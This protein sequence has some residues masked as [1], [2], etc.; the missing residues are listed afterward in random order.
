M[1]NEKKDSFRLEYRLLDEMKDYP[2][3]YHYE[4]ISA[5]ELA[6]RLCCGRFVKEGRAYE[7]TSAAQEIMQY[8]IYLQPSEILLQEDWPDSRRCE[9]CFELRRLTGRKGE[10]LLLNS[11]T[12][13]D[14]KELQLILLCD[15]QF[16]L[17]EEH[18][19][20]AIE[21]NEDRSCY[22]CYLEKTPEED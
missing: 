14:E 15:Y 11:Y 5:Q 22:I 6:L 10:A 1:S 21:M 7:K 3:L 12:I 2:L 16:F 4:A 13:E 17:G 9:P 18:L 8:V 19:V 20:E